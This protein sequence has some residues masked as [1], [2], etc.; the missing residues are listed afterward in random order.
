MIRKGKI[1]RL[2]R[3]IREQL[4][5]RMQEGEQDRKIIEWL[6]TL[7]EVKVVLM[8]EFKGNAINPPNLSHWR[9]GGYQEWQRQEEARDAIRQF[10]AD[11][12]E[13]NRAGDGQ[14]TDQLAVCLTA[15]IAVALRD[16]AGDEEDASPQFQ[17]LRQL[18]ADLVQLRKG[19]HDAQWLRIEREQLELALKK[20]AAKTTARE[21]LLKLVEE[22][23]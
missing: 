23:K 10:G 8:R 7:A 5:L 17:R 4:N 15:R 16:L 12:A 18:C 6:N 1:A 21:A 20:Q 11:A 14:L 3:P 22:I 13:L 2:P 19:D 9:H